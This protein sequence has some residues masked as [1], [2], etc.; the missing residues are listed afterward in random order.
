MARTGRLGA[1]GNLG[2]EGQELRPA[3]RKATERLKDVPIRANGK[4]G[5]ITRK[6]GTEI[7][8]IC[9]TKNIV[10][11]PA[12]RNLVVVR[13]GHRRPLQPASSPESLRLRRFPWG[14]S[15]LLRVM[16]C[17]TISKRGATMNLVQLHQ[18]HQWLCEFCRR[19]E[20]GECGRRQCSCRCA[21]RR[22][23]L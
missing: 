9:A 2:P 22:A 6:P 18:W 12:V 4:S 5:S 10:G 3:Y 16:P 23:E 20:F 21:R 14:G 7:A 19:S 15:D 13:L 11:F 1:T 17:R 8:V